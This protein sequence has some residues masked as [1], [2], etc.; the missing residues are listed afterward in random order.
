MCV[1]T[2][3]IP[4]LLAP[5]ICM[6]DD[7]VGKSEITGTLFVASGIITL[8]QSFF[9]VRLPIV[10]AGTYALLVPT[11]SYLSLPQWKCPDNIVDVI[12]EFGNNESTSSSS[13]TSSSSPLTPAD[14]IISGSDEHREIWKNR[15]REIQ[16]CIMLA[17][18]FEVLVGGSGLVGCMMKFIGPL[19]ICPTVTLLGLSLFK[20]APQM[21]SKHWGIA[22]L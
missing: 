17:A 4:I 5:S 22:I 15:L 21:A 3:T 14:Y 13:L 19:T 2:L 8:V 18:I 20:S 9:G 11:L 12:V 16:G 10:Q 6:F 1:A 7:N